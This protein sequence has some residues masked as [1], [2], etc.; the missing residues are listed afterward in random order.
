MLVNIWQENIRNYLGYNDIATPNAET[1]ISCTHALAARGYILE[2]G[3]WIDSAHGGGVYCRRCGV[4]V[5]EVKHRRLKISYRR[6]PFSHVPE[7]EL[8]DKPGHDGNPHR[9]L[10]LF[11][12]MDT[13]SAGHDLCWDMSVSCKPPVGQVKCL[14]CKKLWPWNNRH[15][16]TRQPC[17]ASAATREQSP[18]NWISMR[19][20]KANRLRCL[21][22]MGLPLTPGVTRRRLYGKQRVHE[23]GSTAASSS[24]S[25]IAADPE[26]SQNIP[27][28]WRLFDDM[29]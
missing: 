12:S 7:A 28:S 27:T 4:F 26:V 24:S 17:R 13:V 2:N 11:T 18:E 23:F 10:S 8:L 14:L 21:Q 20:F 9:L 25:V 29:G 16:L 22:Q 3:H 19:A 1:S 6:C 5:R 15:N